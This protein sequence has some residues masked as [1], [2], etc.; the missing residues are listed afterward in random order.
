MGRG[1]GLGGG[2]R[3]VLTVVD[4][5]THWCELIPLKTKLS[6]EVAQAFFQGV[7]CRHGV[8]SIV[9]SDNGG[10]FVAGLFE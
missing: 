10:E 1:G 4:H 3:Y 5:H 8:P 2:L 6:T 7:I 9:I